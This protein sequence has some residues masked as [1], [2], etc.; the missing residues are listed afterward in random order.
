[1]DALTSGGV[2]EVLSSTVVSQLAARVV[3]G[4][5]V[6]LQ[7]TATTSR[8]TNDKNVFCCLGA[9]VFVFGHIFVTLGQLCH[10]KGPRVVRLKRP[11]A[12]RSRDVELLKA[13]LSGHCGCSR[14]CLNALRLD[15]MFSCLA[16]WRASFADLHKID[17]DRLVPPPRIKA[18]T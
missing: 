12:E 2:W 1:M 5:I 14:S 13:K 3:Q 11:F 4:A 17:Q 9:L 10:N 16:G 6:F 15:E 7:P 8:P 18:E